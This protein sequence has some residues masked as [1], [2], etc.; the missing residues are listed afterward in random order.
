MS[1][2]CHFSAFSNLLES[3]WMGKILFNEDVDFVVTGAMSRYVLNRFS[4]R[5]K[6][7]I[8]RIGT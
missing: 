6:F 3:D 7:P 8:N 2:I 4:R 1:F 5:R